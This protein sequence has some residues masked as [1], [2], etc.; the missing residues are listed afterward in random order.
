M[1]AKL[2]L[3]DRCLS[4][5]RL[6]ILESP[7]YRTKE[8][9][10][11]AMFTYVQNPQKRADTGVSCNDIATP[12]AIARVIH[13][14]VKHIKPKRI[15]DPSCGIGNLLE[16][17]LDIALCTGVETNYNHVLF[18]ESKGIIV[19]HEDFESYSN[20]AVPDLILMNPPWSAHP[21]RGNYTEI[22]LKQITELYGSKIPL[23][24]LCPMGLR[25]N[26][27]WISKRWRWIA[28]NWEISSI[29]AC[30]SNLYP[31]VD[32]HNEI[33]FFNLP[34]LKPHYWAIAELER[35]GIIYTKPERKR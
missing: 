3:F 16:P 13:R 7:H 35:D 27:R 28:E 21:S 26:Q 32:F 29:M 11:T 30:P 5:E 6:S 8:N 18:A 1:A 20:T 23:V 31:T 9:M 22:F 12:P 19:Q 4:K 34:K 33:L 24:L 17:W 15:L 25:L 10:K 14:L 2:S